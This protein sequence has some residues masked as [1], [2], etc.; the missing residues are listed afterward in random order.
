MIQPIEKNR[1]ALFQSIQSIGDHTNKSYVLLEE[2]NNEYL[3]VLVNEAF[4][5]M[6]GYDKVEL[7]NQSHKLLFSYENN[8]NLKMFEET[9]QHGQFKKVDILLNHKNGMPSLVDV[10][11][12][13]FRDATSNSYL[14][15][16]LFD[17]FSKYH[18]NHTL[19]Y[20]EEQ[21]YTAIEK[22][23]TLFNKLQIICNGLNEAFQFNTLSTIFIKQDKEPAL[24]MVMSH[25]HELDQ[26][27]IIERKSEIEYYKQFIELIDSYRIEQTNDL[28]VH[29]YHKKIV[30]V[31]E[32]SKCLIIPI[33][34]HANDRIGVIFMYFDGEI[35]HDEFVYKKFIHK[36]NDL[37]SLAYIYDQKLREISYLAYNDVPTGIPN[38]LGFTEKLRELEERQIFGYIHIIEPTEFTEIVELYGRDAGDELLKQIS[39]KMKMLRRKEVDFIGR[40]SSSKIIAFTNIV[41]GEK[42]P[43]FE[44]IMDILV[45]TPFII[46]NSPVYITLKNGVAPF[47]EKVSYNDSIRFA[48][49]AFRMAKNNAGNVVVKYKN[50][51]DQTLKDNLRISSHLTEAVKNK[52]IIVYFQ[53]KVN[54]K[55]R[56]ISSIE[57]LARWNSPTLGFISPQNFMA[58]AEKTGL[59]R[60]IDL[61]VIEQ[62]LQW[63]ESRKKENK[64]V[65][66]VAVNISPEHFYYPRF[67]KQLVDLVK[68][69]NADP[70]N[71][72]IEITENM[73]LVDLAKA[74]HIIQD[75]NKRGFKTSVDDFGM[76]YSSLNYLQELPIAELKIDRNFTMKLQDSGTYAIVKA[77]LQIAHALNIDTVAEGVETEEQARILNELGCD[78][79]QGY[80]F[81]KPLPVEEFDDK[82]E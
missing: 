67:V 46:Q 73:S 7:L 15:L 68:K 31:K 48:E 22:E 27:V 72:I 1:M 35:S 79:G 21:I 11:S 82:L 29:K 3:I 75:L 66:P 80:L 57:A 6:T 54:L 53:P 61:Q 2:R 64:K 18:L 45:E 56:T 5:Q 20:L 4:C 71:I 9:M 81:S 59:I 60:D 16:L 39:R 62:V 28:K 25:N 26:L 69:Y 36:I 50:E 14:T 43:D 63:F 13:P 23:R 78:T 58:V 30:E 40:F 77:I 51:M 12:I 41:V 76:G 55:N 32:L 24:Q 74:R 33:K 8:K 44:A 37:I 38:R 34:N 70:S 65:V 10:M 49:N 52:E 17:D 19:H 47:N 42:V